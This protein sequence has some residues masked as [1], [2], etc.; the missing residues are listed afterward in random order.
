[1]INLADYHHIVTGDETPYDMELSIA[2]FITSRY[3]YFKDARREVEDIWL[4]AW[5]IYNGSPDAVDHQREQTLGTVGDVNNDWRHKLNTGKGFQVIETVH[6]YLM[7]ALFPNREW[8]DLTPT[9]PGYAQEARIIRKYIAKKFKQGKFRVAFEKYLRQL[10]VCGFSV[11][12]LPW[13]YESI[14]YK[15]NVTVNK[16]PEHYE[17]SKS[18]LSKK[19][20]TTKVVESRVNHNHPE[21]E[22][23]D[24]FDVYIDP[25]ANDPNESDLIR[26]VKKTRADIITGIQYGKYQ[27]ITAWDVVNLKPYKPSDRTKRLTQFQGVNVDNPFHMDDTVEVIEYWGNVYVEGVTI[28]DCHATVIGERLVAVEPNPF[29]AG[30][31]FVV[32]TVTE[33]TTTPYSI[34]LLQPNLGLLH[35]LNIITNQRCDNL[36]L[37]VDEMWTLKQNS[38]L[39]PSEVFTAPGKVF[40][41]DDHDDLR[42][43]QRGAKDFVVSYQEAGLLEQTIDGNSGTGNLISANAARSGER[44]TAAEIQAVRDAGGNRLS[45]IHRHIEETSLIEILN[46]V[47]R[48]AQ[49]FVTEPEMVRVTGSQPGQALYL[50]V[51]NEALNKGYDLEPIGAD[52]VTDKTKYV[53]ERQELISFVSQIPQLAQRL[54]YDAILNDILLHSSFDDP[55]AYIVQPQQQPQQPMVTPEQQMTPPEQAPP[56]EPTN[57]MYDIGG[58][59]LQNAIDANI[60][61][62]GAA[63]LINFTTGVQQ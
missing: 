59:S 58:V 15:Y 16:Q 12:A 40:L 6:A 30:K 32:G 7:G 14:P 46:R 49:Q 5:S 9:N 19:R 1:M 3:E 22:C 43:V 37:A 61:A 26:R 38:N 29:W 57:P 60:Q 52:H 27:G 48:S 56:T 35:Q 39:Q 51:D 2:N 24:V 4:E 55:Y 33:V 8:F 25:T 41:V 47:Y 50:S 53:R 21:F 10:L 17:T 23:L 42:P 11:M 20:A 28:F 44:V 13:R 54:N 62:D 36:E 45:N 34:G 31:P 63:D 18:L